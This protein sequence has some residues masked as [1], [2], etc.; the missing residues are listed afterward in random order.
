MHPFLMVADGVPCME[1]FP[2]LANGVA[3]FPELVGGVTLFP[4]LVGGV[5]SFPQLSGVASFPRLVHWV[6]WVRSHLKGLPV[7]Y[8]GAGIRVTKNLNC[9]LVERTHHT[10]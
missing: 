3:S 5:A 8:L 4:R 9:I 7:R 2:V 1:S 6:A 10:S